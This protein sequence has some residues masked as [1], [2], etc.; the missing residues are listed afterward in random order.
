MHGQTYN[1]RSKNFDKSRI[2]AKKFFAG[3]KIVAKQ[4]A[5]AN[6]P[7]VDCFATMLTPVLNCLAT[8]RRFM[9][10]LHGEPSYINYG[11]LYTRYCNCSHTWILTCP[12]RAYPNK[13]RQL[14]CRIY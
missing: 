11:C 6:V 4:S 9:E 14:M 10:I 7:I 2:V 3:V 8:I 12:Y 5:T 13:H 1:K